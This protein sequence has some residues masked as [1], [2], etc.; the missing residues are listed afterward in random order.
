MFSVFA[1]KASF[2]CNFLK[3][4]FI[5]NRSEL[6]RKSSKRILRKIPYCFYTL[7][8]NHRIGM[9]LGPFLNTLSQ[10]KENQPLMLTQIWVFY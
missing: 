10:M 2:I 1:L 5:G 9:L 8:L 6:I 3:Y 4:A 7:F